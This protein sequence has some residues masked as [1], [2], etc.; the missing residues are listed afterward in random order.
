MDKF[1]EHLNEIIE[2]KHI[3]DAYKTYS[4]GKGKVPIE[5]IFLD[6]NIN[7]IL[8]KVID[9][10]KGYL[11]TN[12]DVDKIHTYNQ[13]DVGDLFEIIEFFESKGFITEYLFS[14][15]QNDLFIKVKKTEEKK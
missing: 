14:K 15:D 3:I 2:I 9:E 6:D 5:E 13:I 4:T 1:S 11:I 7:E 12:N 8:N 10:D